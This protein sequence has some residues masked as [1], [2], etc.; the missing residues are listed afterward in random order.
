MWL[1][2]VIQYQTEHQNIKTEISFLQWNIFYFSVVLKYPKKKTFHIRIWIIW[3]LQELFLVP[4]HQ[5][6][7]KWDKIEWWYL[8]I[9]FFH[10]S[11]GLMSTIISLKANWVL[12]YHFQ[13]SILPQKFPLVFLG[14]WKMWNSREVKQD[15]GE[16]RLSYVRGY[17]RYHSLD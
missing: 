6:Q 16:L 17:T 15:K 11:P 13:F 2:R 10:L 3:I 12:L 5:P 4:Q 7:V 9:S 1:L 14:T 8:I